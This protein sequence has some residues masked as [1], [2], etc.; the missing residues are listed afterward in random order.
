MTA[1][2]DELGLDAPTIGVVSRKEDNGE[3]RREGTSGL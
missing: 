2:I 1:S 3:R